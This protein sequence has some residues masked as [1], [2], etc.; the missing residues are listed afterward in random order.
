MSIDC[1]FFLVI[2]WKD[3]FLEGFCWL[4]LA[5]FVKPSNFSFSSPLHNK[6]VW[7]LHM[8]KHEKVIFNFQI[9]ALVAFGLQKKKFFC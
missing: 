6:F 5:F 1:E 4:K 2:K 7:T 8:K 3:R 9:D